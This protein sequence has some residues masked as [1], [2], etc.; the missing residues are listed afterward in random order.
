M[1]IQLLGLIAI[2][3]FTIFV[4][5]TAKENG[6][7]ALAWSVACIATGLGFQWVIP[8]IV[9]IVVSIILIATGTRPERV[10]EAFGNWAILLTIGSF[11]LSL[12][13]MF[14]I[15]RNVAQLQEEVTAN[16]EVPP[17]PVF[18]RKDD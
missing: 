2:V 13:G 14:L 3:I 1:I 17:P 6:R 8:I 12:L 11:V 15:L 16:I 7:N 5:K 10:Q 9:G 4:A 18:D